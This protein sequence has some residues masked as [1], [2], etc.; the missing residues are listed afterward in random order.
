MYSVRLKGTI[1]ERHLDEID[2]AQTAELK[3]VMD[4]NIMM[5]VL[6]DPAEGEDE[7]EV[8]GNE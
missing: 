8:N 4:Y 6:E 7:E 1:L 5:G 3:A 2:R